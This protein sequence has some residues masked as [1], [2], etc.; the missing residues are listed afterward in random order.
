MFWI[1]PFVSFL[2]LLWISSPKAA[3]VILVKAILGFPNKVLPF[4]EIICKFY[5]GQN[6]PFGCWWYTMVFQI[7]MAL[8]PINLFWTWQ[9]VQNKNT[10]T[11]FFLDGKF[12]GID[13]HVF[14]HWKYME[15]S[16]TCWWFTKKFHSKKSKNAQV[17]CW[18]QNENNIK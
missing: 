10:C 6:K 17:V 7:K 5:T 4:V 15:I 14:N 9:T 2:L 13:I 8:S 18:N 3:V 11:V 1:E 12:F 16:K